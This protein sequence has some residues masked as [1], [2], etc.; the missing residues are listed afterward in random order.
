MLAIVNAFKE[1][2]AYLEGAQHQIKVYTDHRNLE[3]F[4]TTKSLN[5][6]QA[7]WSEL[8]S[9]YDFI[10]IYRPG[11]KNGKPDALSRHPDYHPEGG[12]D[13][14]YSSNKPFLKPGQLILSTIFKPNPTNTFLKDIKSAQSL[15]PAL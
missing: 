3:Y 7:R 10:I 14:L 2:R 6:R 12:G 11:P 4:T 13:P 5:R 9:N 8:L 1:W 15:D